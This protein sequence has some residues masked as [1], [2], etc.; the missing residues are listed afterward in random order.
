MVLTMDR[1]IDAITPALAVRNTA[2]ARARAETN[3]A[4]DDARLIA[5]DVAKQI[6]RDDHTI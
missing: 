1:L 5:D 4:R 6:A 3:A 2:Q